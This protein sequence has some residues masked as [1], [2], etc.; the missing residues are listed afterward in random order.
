MFK[1]LWHGDAETWRV[2]W[3]ASTSSFS[4]H[5]PR[6]SLVGSESVY[7]RFSHQYFASEMSRL[8]LSHGELANLQTSSCISLA[9]DIEQI[10]VE[11]QFCEDPTSQCT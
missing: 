11:T 3:L 7:S 4:L 9:W 6:I 2:T 8:G 5:N 10:E 1:L